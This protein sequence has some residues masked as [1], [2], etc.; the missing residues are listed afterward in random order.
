MHPGWEVS[1]LEPH[2]PDRAEVSTTESS[3]TDARHRRAEHSL[4]PCVRVRLIGIR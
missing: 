1:E 3:R 2:A 4:S